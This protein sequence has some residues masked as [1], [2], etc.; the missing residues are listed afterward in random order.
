MAWSFSASLRSSV[1]GS[2][3]P[4]KA[5]GNNSSITWTWGRRWSSPAAGSWTGRARLPRATIALAN[6]ALGRAG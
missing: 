5:A 3:R 4:R 2:T 6:A 1:A